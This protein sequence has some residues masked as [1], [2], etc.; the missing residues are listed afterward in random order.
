MAQAHLSSLDMSSVDKEELSSGEEEEEREKESQ[1]TTTSTGGSDRTAFH[2][3]PFFYLIP[4]FVPHR[5]I[6]YKFNILFLS[7]LREESKPLR[8]QCA[9]LDSLTWSGGLSRHHGDEEEAK[10]TEEGKGE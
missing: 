4:A 8:D 3:I 9:P 6:A 5:H 1:Q 2:I 7:D 10:E